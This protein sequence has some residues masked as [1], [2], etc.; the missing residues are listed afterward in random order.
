MGASKKLTPRRTVVYLCCLTVLFLA[1]P[2]WPLFIA[3]LCFIAAGEGLRLWACG[4][5]R[6]NKDVIMSGPYAHVKNPLYVGTFLIAV[7]FCLAGSNPHHPVSKYVLFILLPLF[8]AVFV[9]YYFPYKIRVEGDRLFKRF[10]DK[11]SE[12]D[13]NVPH[14]FPRLSAYKSPLASGEGWDL[15]L[16]SENSEY[17]TLFFVVLGSVIVFSKFYIDFI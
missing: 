14:F 2:Y 4:Y 16:L 6:K 8:L 15:K 17:G 7:G 10:G 1:K 3:G 11:F 9:L 12:Y 13:K 5:L